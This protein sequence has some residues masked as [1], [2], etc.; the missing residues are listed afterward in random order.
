MSQQFLAERKFHFNLRKP[1]GKKPT[2]IYL[3]VTIG[4]KQYKLATNTK[5]YPDQWDNALQVAIVSNTISKL[6]N[7]NNKLA[8]ERLEQVKAYYSEFIDYLCSQEETP[9]DLIGVLKT[10]IY[11]P[12]SAIAGTH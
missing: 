12:P 8:N 11:V 9:I 3:V 7:K 4:G 5:V 2:P 10:Y 6:D 1:K